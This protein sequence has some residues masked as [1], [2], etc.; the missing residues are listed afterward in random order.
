MG[1]NCLNELESFYG[2]V[3]RISQ[4]RKSYTLN[5]GKQLPKL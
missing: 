4:T 5:S 3:C 2:P 1:V